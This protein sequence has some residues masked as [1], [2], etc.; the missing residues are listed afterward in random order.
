ME[1]PASQV[2]R[3]VGGSHDTE[4]N[5]PNN[6]IKEVDDE[7]GASLGKANIVGKSETHPANGQ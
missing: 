5:W 3:W 2:G 4:Q 7:C 1:K 6:L